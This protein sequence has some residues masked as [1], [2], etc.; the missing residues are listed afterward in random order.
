MT[1]GEAVLE[2]EALERHY[3]SATVELQAQVW[4]TEGGLTRNGSE[5]AARLVALGARRELHM[6]ELEL[7]GSTVGDGVNTGVSAYERIA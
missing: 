4:R 7:L 1:E 2:R 3:A 5:M 6:T